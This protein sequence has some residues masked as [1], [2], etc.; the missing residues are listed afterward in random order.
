LFAQIGEMFF[1][2]TV[3]AAVGNYLESHAVDWVGWEERSTPT[4]A[5]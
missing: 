3:G 2:P 4:K 5:D 1:F